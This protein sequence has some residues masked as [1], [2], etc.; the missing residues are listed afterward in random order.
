MTL[1]LKTQKLY[2]DYFYVSL[3]SCSKTNK[4]LLSHLLLSENNLFFTK[5]CSFKA[6]VASHYKTLAEYKK[7]AKIKSKSSY[8]LARKTRS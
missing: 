2:I 6:A 8:I 7:Q 5:T 4:I 1:F 3:I